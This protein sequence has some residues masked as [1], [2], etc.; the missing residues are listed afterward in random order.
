MAHK[1]DG[2]LSLVHKISVWTSLDVRTLNEEQQLVFMDVQSGFNT[3]VCGGS[4]TGK[5]LLATVIQRQLPGVTRVCSDRHADPFNTCPSLHDFMSWSVPLS[6][7][8]L[9]D[10]QQ[11]LRALKC[12][13]IDH[14]SVM[15]ADQLDRLDR[16][17]RIARKNEAPFGGVQMVLFADFCLPAPG[18]NPRQDRDVHYVSQYGERRHAFEAFVFSRFCVQHHTLTRYYHAVPPEHLDALKVIRLSSLLSS[19]APGRLRDAFAYLKKTTAIDDLPTQ[20]LCSTY[21]KA[22]AMNLDAVSA[23]PG[24]ARSY[25]AK[26]SGDVGSL[27]V[28]RV[29]T[30]KPGASI[31]FTQTLPEFGIVYGEM[32]TVLQCKQNEVRVLTTDGAEISVRETRFKS[33]RFDPSAQQRPPQIIGYIQQL[34]LRLSHAL[35]PSQAHGRVF[36]Q[37]LLREMVLPAAFLYASLCRSAFLRTVIHPEST[38]RTQLHSKGAFFTVEQAQQSTS[39]LPCRRQSLRSCMDERAPGL[40]CAAAV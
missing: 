7:E 34:P 35:L 3:L 40:I 4:M 36:E 11:R 25:H 12:L 6:E 15:R 27:N 2:S 24:R 32:G 8:L 17:L 22:T 33:M 5:T 14:I 20:L 9:E 1:G 19:Q 16:D 31:M 39:L 13:V 38:L 18:V 29:L 21:S 23:L 10:H 26:E 30:L 37:V 28:P